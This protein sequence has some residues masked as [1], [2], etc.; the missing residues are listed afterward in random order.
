MKTEMAETFAEYMIERY[1]IHL[2]RLDGKPPPWTEDQGL[3]RIYL[4]NVFREDDR[5]TRWI[6]ENIRE[7][8]AE[9]DNLWHLLAA[10]R[11]INHPAA[12]EDL[13]ESGGL[14]EGTWSPDRF[15]TTLNDRHA[16]GER[17]YTTAYMLWG[18]DVKGRPKHYTTA[19]I[20]DEL[21]EHREVIEPNLH[22][23]LRE[24]WD[25]LVPYRGLRSGFL[26][27]EIVSD[28]RHTRYLKDAPDVTHW[29]FAGP[30]AK[31]GLN[32]IFGED[33]TSSKVLPDEMAL[34]MMRMVYAFVLRRW[35]LEWPFLEMREIEHSLCE[36]SKVMRYRLEGKT[37]KRWYKEGTRA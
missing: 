37:P 11:L 36:F 25:A 31:R 14:E 23:T 24:A 4:T 8:F 12:L 18:G 34:A 28:L 20:L 22:R 32:F 33:Y 5:V 19:E 13:L 1:K 35:P 6:R 10:A 15:L 3:Q 9:A 21:W 2:R 30:G 29:A 26:A 17:I 7:P 27:Y 16:L